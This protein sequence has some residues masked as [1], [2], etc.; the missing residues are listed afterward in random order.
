MKPVQLQFSGLNSYR[1]LQVV[2]FEQLGAD[3]LFGIFGP[4]GSGKSSIL[5][6][7]TLALYGGVDR[8]SN[9]T[10]GI[11]HQLEKSLEVSFTFELGG[12]RYLA[13]RRYERNPKDLEAAVAK[14]A[15]LRRLDSD[16]EEVLASK[17]QEVTVKVEEIL[18]IGRDEFSRAV[19]L[20][21]GKF[22]QFLRLTGG[23]RAAML[24]HLFNLEQFGEGLVAKVK[25]ETLVLTQQLQRVEGE[26]QGLGDCSEEAVNQA[27][28]DFKIRHDEYMVTQKAFETI[29]K[30]YRE[31]EAVRELFFKRKT[32]AEKIIQLELEEA[33]MADK[34]SRLDA[35]E[36]SEPLRELISRQKDLNE[37]IGA[38]SI[39]LQSKNSSRCDAVTKHEAVNEELKIAE[40]EYNQKLPELQERKANYQGAREKQKKLKDIQQN[41]DQKKKELAGL[42]DKNAN[43]AKEIAACKNLC[44]DTKTALDILQQERTPFIVN[45]DEKEFI[46]F[47]LTVLARLEES[48]KCLQESKEN[49]MKR[50]SQ[51]EDRWAILIAKVHEMLPDQPVLAG[52]NIE[53]YSKLLLD[54]AE[55]DLDGVRKVKQQALIMNSAAE[56]VKELH[57][58]EPCPVCGSREHPL[59]ASSNDGTEE[60][61]HAID[62]AENRLREIRSWE[63]QLLKAWHDWNTNESLVAES[64]E[65]A[66]KAEKNLQIW[67]AEFENTRRTY[68]RDQLRIRKQEFSDFEKRLHII[69][70]KR[71]TMQKAQEEL[72]G[73]LQTLNDSFQN[74]KINEATIQ[75]ALK[76]LQSQCDDIAEEINQVTGGKDLDDLIRE[77]LQTYNRLQETVES[78][79][80]QEREIRTAAEKLARE[81]AA[82]DATLKANR[83][84]F[85]DVDERLN[86]GLI[87]AGFTDVRQAESALLSSVDRQAIRGELEV[88]RNALAIVRDEMRKLD[89]EIDGRPFEEELFEQLKKKRQELSETVERFKEGVTLAK[90]KLEEIREKQE[91]WYELQRQKTLAIKR[92]SLAE[93]LANLLRGRK[94]VSFLAQEHLRDMTLEASYQLGRLTGQRYA[95]ELIR[96]KDCE[97]VIRDD[98]NGGNRRTINSLSGGEIFLTSLALALALSSKIQ[99]RGKYPLGFFFLDEG[100]GTL[101]EEKLDKVMN[102]LEKLHDKNRMVGVI[103]HVR[104]LKERLPRYLEV[105]AAGEDGSGSRVRSS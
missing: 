29:D 33:K 45:P 10:R 74:D 6:A 101:D 21:Q 78:A 12:E 53:K 55:K 70:Q 72:R 14:Q 88:Y 32:T 79:K 87:E 34:Q 20:P 57:E 2:N 18:G 77:M 19:V 99:L 80:R 76:S 30:S 9:N 58:G 90:N 36:R 28:L 43:T 63:G 92:R 15:R 93:D 95:L 66:E 97:F 44:H 105:T 37:K 62:K 50:K 56:L 82:L 41:V 65:L 23:E 8:A 98:Y 31:A 24:E 4:T 49:Y 22:D 35:A 39:I 5:D 61:E 71:E 94:F 69:D 17:P 81:I 100:F 40:T 64:Q 68:E 52:D 83:R 27:I 84:E 7:I 85:A 1:T 11:I 54:E 73:R 3:G 26:E 104:E 38:E 47:A 46:E 75:E 103:S 67:H 96:D 16:G 89:Q 86:K 60:I 48:E 91:R 102:A 42:G 59:P 51:N 13:E 25:N